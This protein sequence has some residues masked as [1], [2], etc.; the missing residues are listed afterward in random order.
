MLMKGGY[1]DNSVPD[2]PYRCNECAKSFHQLL[3]HQDQKHNRFSFTRR[4][5]YEV[6]LL[7]R[8]HV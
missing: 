5:G 1:R 8:G 3:Q 6:V 2:F 7:M 4:I